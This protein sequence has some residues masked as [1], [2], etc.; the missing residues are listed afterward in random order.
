MDYIIIALLAVSIVLN[1]VNL[2]GKKGDKDLEEK[3]KSTQE[4]LRSYMDGNQKTTLD[5]ITRQ[6]DIQNNATHSSQ[7]Q[8]ANLEAIRFKE[9]SEN[10]QSNIETLRR[11]VSDMSKVIDDRFAI[12]QKQNE[13]QLNQIRETLEKRVTSMQESNEKKLEEMRITVDEKLQ[14]TLEDRISQSF[15]LVSERLEQVYKSLGEMQKLGTG[16]DDLKKV[17]SNVKTRG[18]LGEVQLG[19][20]L[21]QILS[22]EQYQTNVVTKKGSTE[23]VEFAVKLPGDGDDFV[24]LP[25]DAKFPMDAYQN[26]NDAYEKADTAEIEAMAKVLTNRIK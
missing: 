25:I 17:L 5:F 1:I 7:A 26:L 8:I 3:L 10:T 15:K 11:T 4:S 23:R 9:F 19:A 16:V 24:Y 12:F 6:M 13:V 22:P 14:K 18:I 21:E 2:L 20:I